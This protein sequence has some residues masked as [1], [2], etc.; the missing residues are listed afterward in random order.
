MTLHLLQ[1]LKCGLAPAFA[2]AGMPTT[3]PMTHHAHEQPQHA[4][5]D[6]HEKA[7]GDG[8]CAPASPAARASVGP[9]WLHI[10]SMDCAAEESAI[11]RALDTLPGVRSLTFR[12]G[13]RRLRVDAEPPVVDEATTVLRRIGF[14]STPVPAMGAVAEGP[15]PDDHHPGELHQD[16]WQLGLALALAIAAEALEFL[17]PETRPWQILGFVFAGAAIGF[18]GFDVYRKG[19]AALLRGQLN[20]NALM[21]VAVTG[22]FL[23]GQWPEAAMV[24]ALYAHRRADRGARGRPR[25]QRDQGPDGAGARAGRRCGRPTARGGRVPVG[26]GA[27]SMPSCA[28]ARA[29]ACRWTAW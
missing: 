28:C 4:H 26:R 5:D 10:P 7:H 13:E 25:A 27:R 29:S 23:I 19:M 6:A 1:G 14:A 8:C 3:G 20:I 2:S 16:V 24:M 9:G 18:S 21:T 11:R 15:A 12:L 22:A 17:A